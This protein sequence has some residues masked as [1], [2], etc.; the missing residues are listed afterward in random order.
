MPRPANEIEFL[1]RDAESEKRLAGLRIQM[2]EGV[3]ARETAPKHR[4]PQA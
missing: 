4:S 3:K 1:K 2:L